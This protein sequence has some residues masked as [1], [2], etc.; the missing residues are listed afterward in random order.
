MKD[1]KSLTSAFARIM[2]VNPNSACAHIMTG[3]AY[4]QMSQRADAIQEYQAAEKADPDLWACIPAWANLYWRQGETEL[5]EKEV[6][7]ELQHSPTDP[8]ANFIHGQILLNN[9]H[10]RKLNPS[11]PPHLKPIRVMKKHCSVW[12]ERRS[13]GITLRLRLSLCAKRFRST[14]TMPRQISS[15]A[16]PC[17]KPDALPTE[18]GTKD[19]GRPTGEE[20]D[21][22]D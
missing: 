8:V 15:W 7:L 16:R 20:A 9:S 11:F 22:G 13:P 3:T 6:R 4:D 14:P 2:H 18:A 19:L 5:A 12:K 10:W 1:Y 21:G 17:G